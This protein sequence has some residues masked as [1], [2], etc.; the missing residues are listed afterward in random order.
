[1][2]RSRWVLGWVWILVVFGLLSAFGKTALA[3]GN[4]DGSPAII[5]VCVKPPNV[6][7]EVRV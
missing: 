6:Q 4:S 2:Q 1:M 7:K 3:Q 5:R